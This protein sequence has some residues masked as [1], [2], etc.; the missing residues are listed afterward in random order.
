MKREMRKER[1][2]SEARIVRERRDDSDVGGWE[3]LVGVVALGD[4][5]DDV[6]LS[7]ILK[8][9]IETRPDPCPRATSMFVLARV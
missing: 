9:K 2:R 4:M 5:D 8:W 6:G 1:K 7:W 3:G